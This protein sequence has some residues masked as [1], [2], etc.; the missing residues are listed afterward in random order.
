MRLQIFLL[1]FFA[2]LFF[3]ACGDK[4]TATQKDIDVA[5]KDI[6]STNLCLKGPLSISYKVNDPYYAYDKRYDDG[7]KTN[8]G[9]LVGGEIAKSYNGETTTAASACMMNS[10]RSGRRGSKPTV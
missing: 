2:S 8:S 4:N 1:L 7:I 9:R 6:I 5:K 10:A 3:S